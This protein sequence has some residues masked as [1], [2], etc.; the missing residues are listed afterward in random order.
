MIAHSTSPGAPKCTLSIRVAVQATSRT[1]TMA[2]RTEQ[3]VGKAV[4]RQIGR[5]CGSLLHRPLPHPPSWRSGQGRRAKASAARSQIRAP[6][7]PEQ[8]A[9]LQEGPHDYRRHEQEEHREDEI[10]AEVQDPGAV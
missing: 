7:P 6:V 2:N 4:L 5:R 9:K 1:A 3:S 10:E 8:P